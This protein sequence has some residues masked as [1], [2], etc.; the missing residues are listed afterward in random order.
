MVSALTLLETDET[1]DGRTRWSYILLV[2]TLRRVSERPAEDAR[3][4]F[5][6]MVFN[7]LISN[8]DDHPRNHAA[9]APGPGWRLSPAYD[10][11][12]TPLVAEDQRDL[13]MACGA[14]GRFANASNLASEC[15]RFLLDPDEAHAII[16]EMDA[17]VRQE[18]YGVA[19]G[20]GVSEADCEAIRRAFVYPGF[21]R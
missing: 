21:R 7:A 9:F 4:L 20:C 14:Q 17:I 5:R 8:I 15:R 3:E 16:D 18:W 19:R 13:A 1:P 2:E 6:R 12:P 11:T 10:L